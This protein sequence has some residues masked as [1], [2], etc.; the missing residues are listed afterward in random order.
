MYFIKPDRCEVSRFIFRA[1]TVWQV[2]DGVNPHLDPAQVVGG[3]VLVNR[4]EH[5]MAVTIL[6]AI[7]KWKCGN[8]EMPEDLFSLLADGQGEWPV[9]NSQ[10]VDRLF[11]RC[12]DLPA[13]NDLFIVVKVAQPMPVEYI[14][15]FAFF[16]N[17]VFSQG[18]EFYAKACLFVVAFIEKLSC[19]PGFIAH[20][21]LLEIVIKAAFQGFKI[22]AALFQPMTSY[23]L[24][25]AVR[26]AMAIAEQDD[27]SGD[28]LHQFTYKLARAH[29]RDAAFYRMLG[30]MLFIGAKP[31]QRNKVFERFYTLNADLIARF[32]AGQ[33][34]AADKLRILSGKPP[35]PISS[36]LRAI[37][38]R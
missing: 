11:V 6:L 4:C 1:D 2:R 38:G 31:G 8:R 3:S 32:Y 24:P 20:Q 10:R 14:V 9:S 22:F 19:P 33:T 7:C 37:W 29:W 34:T 17:V 35:I 30:K 18:L 15:L 26:T 23:S 16:G 36:A 21:S 27:F 13:V 12:D 5:E 28:A 25:D